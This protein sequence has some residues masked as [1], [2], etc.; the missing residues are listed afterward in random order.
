LM[1]AEAALAI[2][3]R[4][5]PKMNILAIGFGVKSLVLLLVMSLGLPMMANATTNLLDTGLR[6]GTALIGG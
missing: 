5:A 3:T 1:M 6:A 2:A 4:A